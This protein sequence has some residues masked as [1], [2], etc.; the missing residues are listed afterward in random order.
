MQGQMRWVI[1]AV[2]A[3]I[4]VALVA[5]VFLVFRITGAGNPVASIGPSLG[6]G[7]GRPLDVTNWAHQMCQSEA[8]YAASLAKV[9]DSI[10]P[11]TLDLAA[12]KQ[13]ANKI[14]QVEIDAANQVAKDLR[15]ITAPDTAATFHNA[16]VRD[17]DEE[18]AATKEQLDA[19]A[20]ANTAQQIVLANA[21]VRFRRDASSQNLNAAVQGLAPDVQAALSQ[22]P[23]CQGSPVPLAPASPGGVPVVPSQRPGGNPPAPGRGPA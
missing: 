20:K 21:Q 14:G 11:S 16:L 4:V 3:V 2:A 19:I 6:V 8:N 22:E 1:A 18:V 15:A 17:A 13:R 7:R 5:A 12:R 9:V 10:D 23:L